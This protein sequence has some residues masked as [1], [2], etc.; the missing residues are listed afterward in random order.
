MMDP[1]E[2]AQWFGA[3]NSV[4]SLHHHAA[5]ALVS[6]GMLSHATGGAASYFDLIS[7]PYFRA[8]MSTA[9][10]GRPF[11]PSPVAYCRR[12]AASKENEIGSSPPLSW[13]CDLHYQRDS[14]FAVNFWTSLEPAG[15]AHGSPTLE[16]LAACL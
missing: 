9:F 6:E 3:G 7:H 13:H 15:P 8:F 10:P 2:S 1:A 14:R 12:N 5:H 11:A 4:T 16:T